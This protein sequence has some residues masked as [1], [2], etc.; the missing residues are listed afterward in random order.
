MVRDQKIYVPS[1]QSCQDQSHTGP[2]SCGGWSLL[3]HFQ[4][5]SPH[6]M[7][8]PAAILQCPS[9]DNIVEGQHV[10]MTV[11]FHQ[12]A[13]STLLSS[14]WY[15]WLCQIIDFY[16]KSWTLL[17]IWSWSS[18]GTQCLCILS[19]FTEM[20]HHRTLCRGTNIRQNT[21]LKC[22]LDGSR[23]YYYCN[24]STTAKMIFSF[25]MSSCS[26]CGDGTRASSIVF[27]TS[28]PQHVFL[29]IFREFLGE[30]PASS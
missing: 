27:T 4:E 26:T 7:F 11:C 14:R 10:L 25:T 16:W 2:E 19:S 6:G 15:P 9:P 8:G 17:W 18:N 1:A 29:H 21:S 5:K 20:C 23:S 24:P 30:R 12:F 3:L 13:R 28:H 22:I